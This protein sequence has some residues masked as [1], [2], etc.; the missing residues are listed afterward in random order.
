[1]TERATVGVVGLGNM[2][3]VLAA[4]LADAGLD[5]VAHDAAGPERAPAGVTFVDSAGEVARQSEIVVLSLPD[6]AA[7][8]TVVE[9]LL[10]ADG[11]RTNLVI[12]TS[13]VG[14]RAAEALDARM[15]EHAVDLVD[16]PVSGGVAGAKARTLLVMV[17]GRDAAVARAEPVLAG[18]TDRRHRVGDRPGLGQA[19]KLANNYCSA[20]AL[21][22]TSEVVAFGLTAGLDL[23]TMLDVLNAA[24]GQSAA[25]SDK[26]PNHVLTGRYAAG[27]AA[28]LMA[29]DVGLYLDEVE[30]AGGPHALADT[31]VALWRAFAAA[32]PDADFTR[33][34]PFIESST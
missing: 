26:F 25:T 9:D 33:I 23:A 3:Q 12:D 10:A 30:A 24:S 8:A 14:V 17:A 4:N 13:T 29:K 11:R 7:S 21:A 20:A 2:G 16:A 31:T 18:L 6:G 15:Q 22:A 28:R 34:F 1:M 5:V 19:M 27:F 32:E